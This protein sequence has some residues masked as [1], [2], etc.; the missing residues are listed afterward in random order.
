MKI[1]KYIK[2]FISS[3][4]HNRVPYPIPSNS[5]SQPESIEEWVD[6]Y[7]LRP[8]GPQCIK[9]IVMKRHSLPDATWVETGTHEGESSSVLSRFANRVVTLEPSAHYFDVATRNLSHLKNVEIVNKSSEEYFEKLLCGLSGNVCFWLD[10]HY[11]GGE[12]F[13]G[14]VDTPLLLE[15][16]AIRR[17]KK[18]LDNISVL[19]DDFRLSYY[20]PNVYPSPKQLAAWAESVDLNWTVEADIFIAK[21]RELPLY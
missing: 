17:H 4:S 7:Q 1:I 19:I 8:P 11:S 14:E 10:G 20:Q 15:L 12:T 6:L 5:G 18:K 13:K 21:N 3:N 16:N 2:S 9:H